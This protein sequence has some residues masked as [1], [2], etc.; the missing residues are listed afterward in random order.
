MES[1]ILRFGVHQ[2]EFAAAP[3]ILGDFGI[4]LASRVDGRRVVLVTDD[5]VGAHYGEQ[6]CASLRSAGFH[7]AE[8]SFKPGEASKSLETAKALYEFLAR[9]AVGR[10]AVLVAL[11][12]G[13]VGD[14][15]GFVA[16]TWMRG[17]DFAI[18]ATTVE[19]A[20]DASIGGKTAV[21][22]PEGKN[23][24][25]AFHPPVLVV[26]DPTCFATLPQRD[27]RAGLAESIKHAVISSPEFLDWHEAHADRI[28]A[29]DPSTISELIARNVRIKG[30]IVSRDPHETTGER[31]VL[32]FGHTVG[33]AVESAC[34]FDLRH[35]ECVSMGML[36]AAR[37]SEMMGLT[38]GATVD[39]IERVVT[40]FGLPVGLNRNVAADRVISCIRRDKKVRS[41]SLQFVLLKAIGRTTIRSDVPDAVLRE[42]FETLLP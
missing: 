38:N 42:A 37:V 8:H 2:T 16:A 34:D 13:V 20:V 6:M 27:V 33:H 22:L 29:Q 7:T 30:D 23:L 35:G 4:R 31:M 19:S 40:K 36:A 3:G 39:R 15:T 9:N 28:L 41:G 24:V 1:M 5:T 18:C 12:G 14:L 25:G 10:D 26:V 32:N 21:N 11:G 17:V